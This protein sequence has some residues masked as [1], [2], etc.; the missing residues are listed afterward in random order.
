MA[1]EWEIAIME[2]PFSI[3]KAK[4]A[5]VHQVHEVHSVAIRTGALEAYEPEVI[6]VWV[7]AFNP[8][9]FPKNI[10]RME[11]Y[12]AELREGRIGA[13]LAFDLATTELDSVYVAPW[14]HGLGLGSFLLGFAEEKGRLAGLKSMWLDAS[15]NAVRFYEKYGWVK[16]KEHAR[17]RKDVEIPVVRMEKTLQP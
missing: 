10:A 7:D 13:F 9:N 16:V 1:R 4:P 11:F 12:V 5:D 8:Q 6:E 3:R 17:V 14:G 15:L 2:Q